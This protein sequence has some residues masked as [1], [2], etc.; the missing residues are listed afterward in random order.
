[1]R[2]HPPPPNL[3]LPHLLHQPHHSMK[4]PSRFESPDLL[5]ILALEPQS[6]PRNPFCIPFSLS[7]L[8]GILV[9][10]AIR[11]RFKGRRGLG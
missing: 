6:K 7:R 8:S 10:V 2:N 11:L 1:M 9:A 3:L 4:R 5:E